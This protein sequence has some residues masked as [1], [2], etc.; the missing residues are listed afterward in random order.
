MH[1]LSLSNNKNIYSLVEDPTMEKSR[2]P[3]T[4]YKIDELFF[5]QLALRDGMLPNTRVK[6]EATAPRIIGLLNILLKK[7]VTN[8]FTWYL[9]WHWNYNVTGSSS[10]QR[11][12]LPSSPRETTP[13]ESDSSSGSSPFEDF[14]EPEQLEQMK[15]DLLEAWWHIKRNREC[16]WNCKSTTM[17]VKFQNIFGWSLTRI[18]AMIIRAR[19]PKWPYWRMKPFNFLLFFLS[20]I[21][22]GFW[23]HELTNLWATGNPILSVHILFMVYNN[24]GISQVPNPVPF[25][26]SY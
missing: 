14:N 18:I 5:C 23:V 26:L 20:Y 2:G 8:H 12:S 16:G 7:L 21:Y 3:H 1:Y 19:H 24:N 15:E 25:P 9:L 17:H 11:E 6:G 10:Q 22:I 4:L 13:Y